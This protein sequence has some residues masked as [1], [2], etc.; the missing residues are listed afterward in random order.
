ML[1]AIGQRIKAL[2]I[3]RGMNQAALGD[4]LGVGQRAVSMIESGTNQPT[5]KQIELLSD[6]F[7]VSTDYLIKGINIKKSD[8]ELLNAVKEDSAIYSA[9]LKV[10]DSKK[11]LINIAA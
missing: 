6:Y 7:N 4:V 3:E 5:L 2:R 9:I 11:T 8:I 10:I 1:N